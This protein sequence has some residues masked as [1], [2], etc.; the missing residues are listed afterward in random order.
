LA[1]NVEQSSTPTSFP[2]NTGRSFGCLPTDQSGHEADYSK[3]IARAETL[4]EPYLGKIQPAGCY[5][6][7]LIVDGDPIEDIGVLAQ[8]GRS[9]SAA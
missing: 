6:D 7:I 8:D 4:M 1:A 5:A 9:L 2:R 3:W